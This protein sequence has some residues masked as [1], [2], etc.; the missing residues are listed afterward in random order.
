[1]SQT[2]QDEKRRFARAPFDG[3]AILDAG[4]ER[5][6]VE[7]ADLSL[8][9]ARV[10]LPGDVELGTGAACELTLTLDD[11]ELSI[12]LQCHVSHISGGRAGLEFTNVDVDAMQHL[13]RI[14]ELN[15]P[16]DGPLGRFSD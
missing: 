6:Q 5:F 10:L 7:L 9:G 11:T 1:M 14:V 4:K 3:T 8:R 2:D 13:R 12:A 16:E 15:L